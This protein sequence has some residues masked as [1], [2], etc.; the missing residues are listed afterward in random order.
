MKSK[1]CFFHLMFFVFLSH[2]VLVSGAGAA[3][4]MPLGD[5]ITWGYTASDGSGYRRSLYLA[6][7]EAG[8]SV[9]FVG[10]QKHGDPVDFDKN[11]EGHD[12][13]RAD[14]I[15]LGRPGQPPEDIL[16][17]WLSEY[18]PDIILLHIGTNDITYDNESPTAST[19][20]VEAILDT[21]DNHVP[22]AWVVL[23]RIINRIC[24][25]D[26]DPCPEYQKTVD[27]NENVEIMAWDRMTNPANPAWPDKII[28]VDME[29][30][31][32]INYRWSTDNPPGDMADNL[33]P[34]DTGYNKMADLWFTALMG[35]LP[36]FPL[37]PPIGLR[38]LQ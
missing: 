13:W 25:S 7:T 15:V 28:I 32:G 3:K 21:I 5:S 4:I 11:H 26:P 10:S 30:G 38:I 34:S 24:P 22:D 8:Y 12:G 14:Q 17:N 2:I 36:P 23:A 37:S 29:N 19:A 18:E 9:D 20:N 33:H 31:A 35:I 16:Q 27:F 1:A 6:L